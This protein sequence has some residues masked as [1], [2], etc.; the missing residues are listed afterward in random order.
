M[1]QDKNQRIYVLSLRES[2]LAGRRIKWMALVPPR[3][4]VADALTK[5][6]VSV[7]MMT[8]LTTGHLVIENEETHHVQMKRLPPKYEI[9][10][11][12]LTQDDESLIKEF[13]QVK[14]H[15]HNLWWTPMMAPV[16]RG[17]LPIMTL[18]GLNGL[19]LA[20]AAGETEPERDGTIFHIM[21]VFTALILVVE[22][23]IGHFGGRIFDWMRGMIPT[24]SMPSSMTQQSST[25]D[26][27]TMP[28]GESD[29]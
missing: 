4:M 9:E 1:P 6:M 14:H 2:R 22:R 20:Q 16:K 23:V 12:D 10:E 21:V 11:S 15:S 13:E 25:N 8:L 17:I 26:T 24:T 19:R 29:R 28:S 7:Q 18:M 5:P 3:S 27:M